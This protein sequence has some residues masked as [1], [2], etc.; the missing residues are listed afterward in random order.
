MKPTLRHDDMIIPN[1][2]LF[3]KLFSFNTLIISSIPKRGHHNVISTK[4]LFV[5]I[6]NSN[7]LKTLGKNISN[8]VFLDF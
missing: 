3:R 5:T 4:S 2:G 1:K 8:F 6:S 7:V